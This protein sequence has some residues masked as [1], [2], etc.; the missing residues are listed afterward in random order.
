MLTSLSAKV[1]VHGRDLYKRPA[2]AWGSDIKQALDQA[3]QALQTAGARKI[4][5]VAADVS[6]SESDL[7]FNLVG[8]L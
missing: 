4:H 7:V 5:L 6:F 8:T 2:E 3:I 1:T